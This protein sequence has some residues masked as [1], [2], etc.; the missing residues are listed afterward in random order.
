MIHEQFDPKLDSA[1][2]ELSLSYEDVMQLFD[3]ADALTRSYRLRAS[4]TVP[5]LR[6]ETRAKIAEKLFAEHVSEKTTKALGI[7]AQFAE[8]TGALEDSV[9]RQ[10][11]R[12]LLRHADNLATVQDELFTVARMIRSNHDLLMTLRD[13]LIPIKARQDL[14]A[15][16]FGD[17]CDSVTMTLI[18]RAVS[19]RHHTVVK[20]IESYVWVAAQI[21]HHKVAIVSVAHPLNS[22]QYQRMSA[23]LQR[24]YGV[25]VDIQVRIDPHVIGG[26]KV[27]IDDD[28]IDGT[29]RK[30]L[31]DIRHQFGDD[32]Q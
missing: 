9:E 1:I 26:A 10:A 16:V 2:D 5:A 7:C 27:E 8:S 3:A 15:T 14:I 29:I 31:D 21:E 19:T 22:H 12:G 11:V 13:P 28:R 25:G 6:G 23:Q 24:I 30:K 20:N 32:S 4:L 18:Q 17:K